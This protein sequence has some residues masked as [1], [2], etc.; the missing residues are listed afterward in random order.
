MDIKTYLSVAIG[1][2]IGVVSIVVVAILLYAL[3]TSSSSCPTGFVFN[4]TNQLCSNA[5]VNG[6]A[7]T[8]A[9]NITADGLTFVGNTTSQL[10]TAGTLLGVV[11]LL[12][13]IGGLVYAGWRGYQKFD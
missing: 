9:G 4:Q 11:L 10:P 12:V 6:Q 7:L 3:K 2:A 5:S 8:Y 1:L 13:V